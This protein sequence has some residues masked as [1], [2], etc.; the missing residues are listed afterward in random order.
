ML[1]FS[2]VIYG[3]SC[4]VNGKPLLPALTGNILIIKKVLK[5]GALHVI[6]L[7]APHL[8][9]THSTNSPLSRI[10]CT[11]V[12]YRDFVKHR[13]NVAVS[14]KYYQ[15][16]AA[17]INRDCYYYLSVLYFTIAITVVAI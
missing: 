9:R 6:F 11:D 5:L 15:L 17:S 16:R 1:L 14:A 7:I 10:L 8:Q 12:F 4:K 2:L 3:L 13:L